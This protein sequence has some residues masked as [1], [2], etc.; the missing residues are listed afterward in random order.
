MVVDLVRGWD[1]PFNP[2]VVVEEISEVLKEY[3]V[4]S[5][6][7]D[8]FA[9]EWPIAEFKDHG[10]AYQQAE[11][12]KSELYLGFVPVT[13]SGGIELVDDRRLLTQ[14]RRLERRRGRAGK[15]TIDHPP[16]LHDDLA[17]AVAGLSCLLSS[18]TSRGEGGFNPAVHVSDKRMGLERGYP[19]Y[20]GL[21]L[22][23]PVASCIGQVLEG[24][25][26]EI[27]AAFAS[28]GGIEYHLRSRVLPYLAGF[29]SNPDRI[30]GCYGD[31]VEEKSQWQLLEII[32][33]TLP[34][35][36]QPVTM[37]FEARREMLRGVLSQALP[38]SFEPRL[39][40]SAEAELIAPSLSRP[41][42]KRTVYAAVLDALTLL[43]S[44]IEPAEKFTATKIEVRGRFDPR[45]F[46]YLRR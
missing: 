39:R 5:V 19:V 25:A 32:E 40:I 37:G 3:G 18:E 22:N 14:L 41:W 27:Y 29:L 13:N 7:G 9:A 1:P 36:W 16:R 26:I 23:E 43:V 44:R 8:R 35:D 15:D 46:S 17:N 28:D 31:D 42:D 38:F 4:L 20:I 33:K 30:R 34:A 2:K 6:T 12:N 21:T 45:S 10:I 24:G 11:K